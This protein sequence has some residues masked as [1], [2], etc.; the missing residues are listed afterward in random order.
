MPD[1][2]ADIWFDFVCPWCHIGKRRWE[3]ALAR[4]EHRDA[5]HVR[6]RSFELDPHGSREARLTIPQ[7]M[8]QDLGLSARQAA[9]GVAGL[10][11]LA[12]DLGLTY[13]LDQARPVN[14]FDAHRLL[15]AAI[16]HGL[17]D[18]V[19][20]RLLRAYTGEGAHLADHTTLAALADEAGFPAEAARALLRGHDYADAV[21]ADG[22]EARRRGVSGVPSFV[23]T[24]RRI[25]AGAQSP[26]VLLEE[27]RLAWR[28]VTG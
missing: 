2:T 4:F 26:D 21:R 16:D 20:E 17:G 27:L 12:A 18:Q 15:H 23:I 9:E 24:G 5:V 19:R 14:S 25:I 10:T 22:D 6:W 11:E 7:R 3:T 1:I 8:Q 28:R 13:R